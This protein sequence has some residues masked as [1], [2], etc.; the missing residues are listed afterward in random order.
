MADT[1]DTSLKLVLGEDI[2]GIPLLDGADSNNLKHT[3]YDL[4]IGDI[5][6][7]GKQG[8][9]ER[10]NGEVGRYA[11]APREAVWILSKEEFRLPSTVTGV[12]T[13]RTSFTKQGLVAFNVGIID[14]H[15]N[16]PVS[17]VF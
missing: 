15:Y 8:Y 17:T 16:G 2:L 5:F 10:K 1:E 7:V 12:A 11:I 6:P 9:K 4:T 3:T 14:P 13:L